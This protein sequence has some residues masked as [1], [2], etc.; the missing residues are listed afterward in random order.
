MISGLKVSFYKSMLVYVNV[1]DIWLEEAMVMLN[2]R[3]GKIPFLYLSL[4]ISYEV[5]LRGYVFCILYLIGFK[6]KSVRVE[7]WESFVR[8]SINFFL[9]DFYEGRV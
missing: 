7:E 1:L 9:N 5:I 4:P 6:K 3:V 8:W 2:C